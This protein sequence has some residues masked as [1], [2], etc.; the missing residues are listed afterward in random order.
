[1][2]S[3]L[4]K[5]MKTYGQKW[6]NGIP[7]F[8]RFEPHNADQFNTSGVYKDENVT[9][10]LKDKCDKF[11]DENDEQLKSVFMRLKPGEENLFRIQESLC[12][13]ELDICTSEHL[14]VI[15]PN[16]L[17]LNSYNGL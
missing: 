4:C 15:V 1:M 8:V 12:L 16:M 9:I 14:Q 13:E 5:E 11:L 6:I 17:L 2:L 7:F 10:W 3:Q